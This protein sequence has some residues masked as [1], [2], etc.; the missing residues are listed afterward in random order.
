MLF[1]TKRKSRIDEEKLR[2]IRQKRPH[3]QSKGKLLNIDG[4]T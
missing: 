4:K 1:E 3:L 2:F